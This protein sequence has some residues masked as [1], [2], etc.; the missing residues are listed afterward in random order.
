[1]IAPRKENLVFGSPEA[2][3]AEYGIN[4][5]DWLSKAD[6]EEREHLGEEETRDNR[7]LVVDG[8]QLSLL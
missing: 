1:L 7:T 6:S 3:G 8:G 2:F 4:D 5:V